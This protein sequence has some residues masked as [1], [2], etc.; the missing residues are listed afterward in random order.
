MD[1]AEEEE[2][3][4]V[5]RGKANPHHTDFFSSWQLLPFSRIPKTTPAAIQGQFHHLLSQ[6]ACSDCDFM[7]PYG[8]N[9][10][11]GPPELA[12]LQL[13]ARFNWHL[14]DTL[15][16]LLQACLVPAG[17][18]WGVLQQLCILFTEVSPSAFLWYIGQWA[19]IRSVKQFLRRCIAGY[20]L[21]LAETCFSTGLH[22]VREKH[23]HDALNAVC[24]M[25]WNISMICMIRTPTH[26]MSVWGVGVVL[27]RLFCRWW[28]WTGYVTPSQKICLG[29]RLNR[30][31]FF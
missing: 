5:P 10:M 20:G 9:I 30:Y 19:Q 28:A 25:C 23:P 14:F 6:R 18:R 29:I 8:H 13:I 7:L 4:L 12:E 3:F 17:L 22:A 1:N 27:S 11:N 31:L 2:L 15:E 26:W 21:W 16:S 24:S